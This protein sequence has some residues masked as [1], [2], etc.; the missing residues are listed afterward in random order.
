MEKKIADNDTSLISLII[1]K[2]RHRCAITN[3]FAPGRRIYT[4]HFSGGRLLGQREQ[5]A[6]RARTHATYL[7]HA[8]DPFPAGRAS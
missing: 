7:Q 2:W 1:A 4:L 3:Y 5:R 6:H 8:G